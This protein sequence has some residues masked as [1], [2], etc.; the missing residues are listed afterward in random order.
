MGGVLPNPMRFCVPTVTGG[1]LLWILVAMVALASCGGGEDTSLTTPSLRGLLRQWEAAL[2]PPQSIETEEA[3]SAC[4]QV[5]GFEYIPYVR[6]T[7]PYRDFEDES[8]RENYGYGET[9]LGEAELPQDN[10]NFAYETSLSQAER[11][12]YIVAMF[13]PPSQDPLNATVGSPAAQQN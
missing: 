9:T 13:G 6:P 2:V 1:R 8:F 12:G 11:E 5:E 10:P 3:I 4:M 7:V